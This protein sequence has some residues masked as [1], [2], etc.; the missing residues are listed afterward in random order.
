MPIFLNS[1]N[2]NFDEALHSKIY[3]DKTGLIEYTNSVIS[4][5]SKFICNSRPRRFGKSMTADMLCA[6]YSKGYDSKELF[7]PYNISSSPT[8]EKYLHQYDVLHIDVQW[9]KDQVKDVNDIVNYIQKSCMKELQ[10]TYSN[11]DYSNIISLSG[12]LA[13]INDETKKQFVII[14]DEW[15]VLIRDNT[16]NKKLQNEYINFL[17]GLFK[18]SQPSRYISLAYLTGILPIKRTQTQSALNNFDEY[19]MLNPGPLASFFGFTEIEVKKLCQ[20]YNQDFNE[21]KKW[22]DGYLLNNEHIYNPRAV[23]SAL[24]FH[25][26]QSYWTQ[27]SSYESINSL[28][29]MDFDGLKEA[30]IDML[31]G[32]EVKIQPTTFQ[33]DMVSFKNKDDVLTALV[34]LGYLGFKQTFKTVFIPNEEIRQEFMNA[35]CEDKWKDLIQFLNESD[36]IL[37]ATLDFDEKEVAIGIEKIHDN[38]S[39]NITYHNKNSLSCVLTIAYLS[40]LKCYFKPIRELPTGRGFA[41]FVY[42]PKPEYKEYYP[43]LL[44]ELKWNQNA[45][46]AMDQIKDKKYFESI[47]EY[48]ENL[49]LVGIVYNKTTK[50]H[51]CTIEKLKTV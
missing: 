46:T 15:D 39:S 35:V 11:I 4:T 27:T 16:N 37:D 5:T 32:N 2:E 7:Q 13:K 19:T 25:S 44:V 17:R 31:S 1:S 41:D 49:L 51:T 48:T 36:K 12:T 3:V 34:H 50:E 9:C 21:M 20:K 33:N 30:I 10:S 45:K 43:A 28:I 42:I 40:T 14:I 22:Y 6:Y 24:T 23:V 18:G 26:L 38:Y 29:K 8:F 47:Q